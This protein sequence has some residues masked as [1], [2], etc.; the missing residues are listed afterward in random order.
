MASIATIGKWI[1]GLLVFFGLAA[2]SGD[3]VLKSINGN[4]ALITD[5][6]EILTTETQT[7]KDCISTYNVGA[8]N[9]TQYALLVDRSDTI[10]YRHK[11]TAGIHITQ[12]IAQV[13]KS[14][15]TVGAMSFGVIVKLNNDSAKIAIFRGLSFSN[16]SSNFLRINDNYSP[17]QYKLN[18]TGDSLQNF[19]GNSYLTN[20]TNVQA[21]K[22]ISTYYGSVLPQV[23]DIVIRNVHTSGGAYVSGATV[24]YH[25]D[26]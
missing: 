7:E 5:E 16:T 22:L 6:G 12:I 15:N 9:T 2:Y 14:A 23:G 3:I 24:I 26:Y 11:G 19:V 20:D 13:D 21:D 18:V 1:I 4:Y 8:V 10:R 17:S 25:G